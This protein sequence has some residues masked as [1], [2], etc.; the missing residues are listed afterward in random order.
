MKY[1]LLNQ[2]QLSRIY[3]P[4]IVEGWDKKLSGKNKRKFQEIF[5]EKERLA[6]RRLYRM[7]YQWH[8]VKGAP[9]AHRFENKTLA[10]IQ[11][12]VAFFANI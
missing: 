8:L 1:V 4:I 5:S 3:Y 10:L 2:K 9:L 6:L 7:F 11:R 12:G